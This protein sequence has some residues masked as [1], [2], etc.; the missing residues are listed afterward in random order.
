MKTQSFIAPWRNIT[1]F[2]KHIIIILVL[3]LLQ[4]LS[5][6]SQD[7][8]NFGITFGG[9]PPFQTPS[10]PGSGAI[11]TGDNFYAILY[12]D[13]TIPNPGPISG[14]I[15]KLDGGI[16]TT[17][18]QFTNSVLAGYPGGGIAVD[19]E[20]SWQLTDAQI[21]NLLAG[22]W[23]A[24]VTYSDA[25]YLGQVTVV[26]EPSSVTLLLG[27]LVVLSMSF[28]RRLMFSNKVSGRSAVAVHVA[29]RRWFSFL[30]KKIILGIFTSCLA[31]A[32]PAQGVFQASLS[33][34]SDDGSPAGLLL[35]DFWFQVTGNEVEFK[36]YVTP[37]GDVASSL[38][39]ILSVPGG[40]IEFSM[41]EG[42]YQM[43]S[44]FGEYNPF[45]PTP[46]VPAAYDGDG[47]PVYI[48]APVILAGNFYTGE[49]ALPPGFLDELLA[50]NGKIELNSFVGGNIS[51]TP[52]PEPTTL[53]LGLLPIGCLLLIRWRKR[54]I[55]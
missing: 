6:F 45:L 30:R 36:A 7:V 41:G 22:Q 24:K 46:L 33:T 31:L 10:I 29:G 17:V 21:Q 37:I 51:F 27:S 48:V 15:E 35:G 12:M 39:P 19:Y 28:Y 3:G 23:Y 11:L 18:F 50:G 42:S 44:T 52:T 34:L 32:A 43:F 55:G 40:S 14:S 25:S 5:A 38:N 49:F 26:P 13:A 8:V 16:F 9:N 1:S 54:A 20:D 53:T 2:M 47:N 4:Q